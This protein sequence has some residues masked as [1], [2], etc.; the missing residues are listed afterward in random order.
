MYPTIPFN[1]PDFETLLTT[2]YKEYGVVVIENVFSEDYC[3]ERMSGIVSDFVSMSPTLDINNIKSTW[4]RDVLPPQTRSGLFQALVSNLHDVW[5]IRSDPNVK[6]IFR[7]LYSDLRNKKIKKFI[8]S[9][10][11]INIKPGSIGPITDE[12]TKDWAHLDQTSGEIFDC[13]QGQAVLTNTSACLVATP[14]SH[15]HFKEI[16]TIANVD[17]SKGGF[18]KFDPETVKKL[19]NF[20]KSKDI[21]YQIPILSK[22]GSFIVWSSTAIHSAR[23]QTSLEYPTE[24]DVWNGWRGVIYICYRP[25]REFTKKEMDLRKKRVDTNRVTPH[26]SV[27]MFA[28]R[29]GGRW[30]DSRN[31]YNLE[32]EAYIKDPAL[33]YTKVKPL[34][35]T[36]KQLALCGDS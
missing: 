12:K 17:S 8:V 11:G 4:K 30:G 6:R 24:K 1:C 14:K 19:K 21:S 25:R 3:N 18:A 36:K 7:I 10:D 26:T 20:F 13:I 23:L 29:P 33:V 16:L 5:K 22:K 31:P 15:L 34:E 27:G 35:L 32:I 28:K 9:G 2:K